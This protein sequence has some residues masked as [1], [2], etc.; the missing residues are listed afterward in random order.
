MPEMILPG[1]YIEEHA[2]ALIVSGAIATG[3]IGIVGTAARGPINQVTALSAY[4]DALQ[5]YALYDSLPSPY[6]SKKELSLVRALEQAYANGASTVYAVRITSENPPGTTKAV[7]ARF[8]L[9]SA[10]AGNPITASLVAGAPSPVAGDESGYGTWGNYLE[11]TGDKVDNTHTR[12]NIGYGGVQ[13]SYTVTSGHDL[14]TQVNDPATG[15]ALVH[16][17]PGAQPTE[18]PEPTATKLAPSTAGAD[19]ADTG[20][21]DYARGLDLLTDQDVQI[22]VAAG[23]GG[24]TIRPLLQ[25]HVNDASTDKVKRER[26]A[27]FGEAV[28]PTPDT[29]APGVVSGRLIY[30]APGIQAIDAAQ[31]DPNKQLV[32]LPSAYTAAVVAGMLSAR[33]PQV[34]ITNQSVT[35]VGLET[36]YNAAKLET[37]VT[38]Q[39]LVLEDRLGIKVVKGIT[40]DDGAF[41]QITTRRI[42]DLARNG[43][44]DNAEPYIGLLNNDRVR[45]A[46]SGS[47]NG[48]LAQMV[49]DEQLESY[50]LDVSA[51]RDQEIRGICVVTMTLLPTFSIDFIKVI[52]YLQ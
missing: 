30:T 41:R 29:P 25:A 47:I 4:S 19:G 14:I 13:E 46:L 24:A 5:T 3:N 45:K 22:V 34:S 32:K 11:I 8:D 21:A 16:A 1:V 27:V 15:S 51:T 49:L 28:M 26:I 42:V 7:A 31:T 36:K 6:G 37:L 12:V 2:E 48:F 10:S 52:M 38:G 39:V 20:P 43:V 35:A 33:D 9:K 23:Q 40:T 50:T 44:R 17:E 18:L